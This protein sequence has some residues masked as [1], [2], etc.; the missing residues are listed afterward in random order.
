M[1]EARLAR[2]LARDGS[3]VACT[4]DPPGRPTPCWR[5]RAKT[6]ILSERD[7]AGASRLTGESVIGEAFE[8]LRS[9][10][11]IEL[12]E[13]SRIFEVWNKDAACFL[14]E[15]S[16]EVLVPVGVETGKPF[17]RGALLA[18]VDQKGPTAGPSSPST[19][20]D[21]E[22]RWTRR[23]VYVASVGLDDDPSMVA[24]QAM[25]GWSWRKSFLAM[26]RLRHRRIS[27]GLLPSTVRRSM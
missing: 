5:S 14:T 1:M 18:A 23:L 8:R 9:G 15:N 22:V 3:T 7:P 6:T 16:A 17:V 25:S 4:G 21:M 24:R 20:A 26:K 10:A 2:N 19:S 12:A 13:H 27:R 11:G